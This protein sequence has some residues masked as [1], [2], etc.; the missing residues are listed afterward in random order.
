VEVELQHNCRGIPSVTAVKKICSISKVISNA[1]PK[2]KARLV[3]ANERWDERLKPVSK[4]FRYAFDRR[5]LKSNWPK[6]LR[7]TGNILFR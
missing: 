7:L 3:I 6:V 2:N 5:I 4:Y 1:V